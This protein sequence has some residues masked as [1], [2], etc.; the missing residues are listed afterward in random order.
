MPGPPPVTMAIG[1]SSR[2]AAVVT[3][4]AKRREGGVAEAAYERQRAALVADLERVYA[5]LD[6]GER[7]PDGDRGLA[8]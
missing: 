1:C 5:E 8:A 7:P 4:D 3:I 2:C 6:A